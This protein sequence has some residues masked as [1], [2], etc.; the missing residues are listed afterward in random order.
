MA[1]CLPSA[2]AAE[3]QRK[4]RGLSDLELRGLGVPVQRTAGSQ[5][6]AAAQ[7]MIKA[8]DA[9][10]AG[11]GLAEQPADAAGMS[12]Q[13]GATAAGGTSRPTDPDAALGAGMRSWAEPEHS[14]LLQNHSCV[15]QQSQKHQKKKKR[16]N[17]KV[18]DM[19]R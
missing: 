15:S 1:A 5:R 3:R 18:A 6:P 19:A 17:M 4:Q 9:A 14:K 12:E 13:H 7:N 10:T 2:A 8:G 16:K 11:K